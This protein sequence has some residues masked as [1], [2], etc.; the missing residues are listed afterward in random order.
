MAISKILPFAGGAGANV[1]SQEGYVVEPLRDSGNIPGIARSAVNN[2]ALRQSTLM[3]AALAKYIADNQSNDVTDDDTP[4]DIALWLKGV[5]EAGSADLLNAP[6]ATVAAAGTINLTAGA[7]D[8]SQLAISGTGVNING[9]TVAADRFFVVKMT[10]AANTLVNSASLVTGRGAN[11]PVVA[12]DTF[13]M[14][15]TA[16]NTVEIVCGL[17]LV[18]RASGSG[19]TWQNLTGSRA[20]GTS[21]TNSTGRSIMITVYTSQS[22]GPTDII[23]GGVIAA[24]ASA[25]TGGEGVNA[26]AIIPPGGVYSVSA[27]NTLGYW[28]ELRT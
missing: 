13:L 10:G 4:E 12:G 25:S 7:P 11:I 18:D 8:T 3:A 23:V 6:I 2:K 27:G 21:Y 14:R 5:I 15:S 19:Q 1:Q 9:F 20:L 16:A 26:A 22:G 28:A 24:R 17:F